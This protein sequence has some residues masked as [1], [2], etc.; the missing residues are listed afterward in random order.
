MSVGSTK[1]LQYLKRDCCCPW[2]VQGCGCRSQW[3][4]QAGGAGCG[5]SCVPASMGS[6]L[7]GAEPRL[8]ESC[9]SV[10]SWYDSYQLMITSLA[11]QLMSSAVVLLAL[12]EQLSSVCT[13]SRHLD[14]LESGQMP[15]PCQSTKNQRVLSVQMNLKDRLVCNSPIITRD[16]FH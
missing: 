15:V 2:C 5:F 16:T 12:C 3:R 9:F 14:I 1:A 10:L 7:A 13:L 6:L 8:G 11:A 4:W